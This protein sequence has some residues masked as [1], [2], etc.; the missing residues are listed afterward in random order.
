MAPEIRRYYETV[1][2]VTGKRIPALYFFWCKT[3]TTPKGEVIPLFS[4]YVFAQHADA[5]TEAHSVGRLSGVL[6]GFFLP[7]RCCKSA[8]PPL[9]ARLRSA[10]R[11]RQ[12][13]ACTRPR[14]GF[15]QD[16]GSASE[17]W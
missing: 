4:R 7:V 9:S 3:V 12:G 17:R 1:D 15:A 10:G 14:W 8:M 16:Q 6:A 11:S 13:T 5:P 2:P